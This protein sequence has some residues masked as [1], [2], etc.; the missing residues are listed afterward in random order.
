MSVRQTRRPSISGGYMRIFASLMCAV[1]L[2]TACGKSGGSDAASGGGGAQPVYKISGKLISTAG[3]TTGTS[4][5]AYLYNT[6][7]ISTPQNIGTPTLTKTKSIPAGS[8]AGAANDYEFEV[9]DGTYYLV[10]FR[11]NNSDTYPTLTID[12]QSSQLS[13]TVSGADKPNQDITI[14]LEAGGTD[15]YKYMNAYTSRESFGTQPPNKSD[16]TEGTG[17]CRGFYMRI[18]A[19]KDTGTVSVPYAKLPNGN[20]KTLLNDGGCGLTVADNSAYSYDYA[21]GDNAYSFGINNPDSTYAGDYILYYLSDGGTKYIH[22][23]KD[24]VATVK[25][26]KAAIAFNAPY[27]ATDVANSL[28]T[29]ITWTAAPGTTHHTM[30]INGINGGT[31]YN[32]PSAV[33][34][35]SVTASGL[36]S[37]KAYNASVISYD[38]NPDSNGDYDARLISNENYF[39]YDTAGTGSGNVVSIAGT[40]NNNTNLTGKKFVLQALGKENRTE[41]S[42]LL[43]PGAYTIY[44]LKGSGSS[45]RIEG[46]L[47]VD[48]MREVYSSGNKAYNVRKEKLTTTGNLTGQDLQANIPP[49]LLSP[50][51]NAANQGITPTITWQDYAVTAVGKMP[52]G[53]WSYAVMVGI[54]K[55]Q[56]DGPDPI[57]F[58]L[59][60]TATGY[61]FASPAARTDITCMVNNGTWNEG[62]ST[63]T[64]ALASPTDLTSGKVLG[65]RKKYNSAEAGC[66]DGAT[67]TVT[68]IGGTCSTPPVATAKVTSGKVE[69]FKMTTY[70]TCTVPPT[71][72][73]LPGC[74]P[75]P[76]VNIGYSNIRWKWQVGIVEC[77]Y[78]DTGCIGP[79]LGSG[80]MWS[81]SRRNYLK[82][83]P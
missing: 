11:D 25:D 58:L 22:I 27:N 8:Y 76:T 33:S 40:L 45:G 65:M 3:T 77:A 37:G 67:Q 79:L 82:T 1:A 68:F 71:S 6:N 21:S 64:G 81:Q 73:T 30:S 54:D 50:A 55:F 39:I 7:Y 75:Q 23:Q 5:I 48:G 38:A 66:T 72:I 49:T 53:S 74:S 46:A 70:G 56:A 32:T 36:T 15:R 20:V 62:T 63:C 12:P 14:N 47:D 35:A 9:A 24:N 51:D 26:L 80:N 69:S 16:G 34:S 18:E 13:V 83:T 42:A 59:P 31:P 44:V 28:A 61:N 57:T 78:Y 29:P 19:E 60:S 41:A 17:L 10:A 52:G 4:L 43:D 2:L